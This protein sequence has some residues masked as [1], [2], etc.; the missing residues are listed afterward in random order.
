MFWSPINM[1]TYF[2][3]RDHYATKQYGKVWFLLPLILGVLG[4][5]MAFLILKRHNLD[6]A[7]DCVLIGFGSLIL[8]I[9]III[10]LQL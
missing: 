9:V 4:G 2:F 6:M 1:I 5:F 10:T 7:K 3:R 8:Q